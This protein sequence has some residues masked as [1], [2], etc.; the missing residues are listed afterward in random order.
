MIYRSLGLLTL[1]NSFCKKLL[2]GIFYFL[3][4]LTGMNYFTFWNFFLLL[5]IG[6]SMIC[7][8]L[9]V[10]QSQSF[11]QDQTFYSLPSAPSCC[12]HI[13]DTSSLSISNSRLL[14]WLS[15]SV[16]ITPRAGC[17]LAPRDVDVC[18]CCSG[19]GTVLVSG[20]TGCAHWCSAALR[21][22]GDVIEI[23]GQMVLSCG[24]GA[25]GRER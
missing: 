7:L 9:R 20:G 10:K 19:T 2:K 25:F 4:A 24:N 6:Y 8:H 14:T 13:T 23:L 1:I 12:L 16:S 22:S 21:E 3:N 15:F 18:P 17:F 11:S 5:P